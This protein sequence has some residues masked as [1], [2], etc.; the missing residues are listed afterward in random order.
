[1][2]QLR[3]YQEESVNE[4]RTALAKYR[5]ILF[6]AQTAFGKTI[7]FTYIAFCSQKFNRKVLILSDRTEILTQNGGALERF[8]IDVDYINPRFRNVPTKNIACGMAQTIQRRVLKPEWREYLS[9]LELVIID[10]CHASTSDYIHPYLSE[11]CFVLGCTAT[12]RRYGNKV[13]QLGELYKAMVKGIT[14][15][16][17]V[18]RGYIAKPRLYSVVAPKLDIPIDQATGDYNRKAL[19]ERYESKTL[20][21]GVVS[22]WMRITPNT[23]TIVFCCSSEQTIEVCKEFNRNGISAKYILSGEFEEDVEYSGERGQIIDEF[24]RNEFM[25]LVNLNIATAGLDVPDIQTVVLNFATVSITRYRQA[26]GRGCR[27]AE[28]KTEFNVLDCGENIRRHGGF[29]EEQ[30]WCLWHDVHTGGG[31]QMLKVCD[32]LKPDRNGK[33]GCNEMIPMTCKTCPKCG[34]ILV[35]EKWDYM[36]HLEEVKEN[37]EEDSIEAYVTSRRMEGW[38]MPRILINLCIANPDEMR[39]AFTKGYLAL[40]P[41]KTEK[42]AHKYYYVFMKQFGS[43]IKHKKSPIPHEQGLIPLI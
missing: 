17:L 34:K 36:L 4:I 15:R 19:A 6:Q 38:S 8:G 5:R 35:D 28:G 29:L 23:K 33:Y 14:T 30:S 13:Q 24:K 31:M 18:E 42:D 10:E 41:D 37:S 7:T 22:E 27:I 1:M 2:I 11:N 20:Y 40:S 16:E 21:K 26:M 43:K 25:V 12:P 39:K 9:T 32:P 3:D